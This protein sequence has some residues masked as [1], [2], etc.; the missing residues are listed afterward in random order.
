MIKIEISMNNGEIIK[1]VDQLSYQKTFVYLNVMRDEC[2]MSNGEV[3]MTV[4][5]SMTY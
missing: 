1:K 3:V 2:S 5:F 4:K